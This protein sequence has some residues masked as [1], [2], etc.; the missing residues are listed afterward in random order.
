M[1]TIS[2]L[3]PEDRAAWEVLARGYKAFY[4]T[5]VPD[6]GYTETWR[7]LL[8]PEDLHGTGAWLDGRLVGIAHYLFHATVWQPDYCYLQDLFVDETARG[9]GAARALI[10]EVARAAR[11]RGAARLYWTTK[12]DNVTARALYD[13]VAVFTGFIRYDYAAPA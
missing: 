7:R 3:R 10:E 12:Q 6:E 11:T 4:E 1:I 2:P 5:P 8:G 9:K 13:K